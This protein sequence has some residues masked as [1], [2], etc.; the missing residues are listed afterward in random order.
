AYHGAPL[1]EI[2][3][4]RGVEPAGP[5]REGAGVA[6]GAIVEVREH[7]AGS[8]AAAATHPFGDAYAAR[9]PAGHEGAAHEEEGGRGVA[10]AR[11]FGVLGEWGL[12]L[13]ALL[14]AAAGIGLALQMYLYRPE[15]PAAFAARA[16]A[17]Y[18]MVAGK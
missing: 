12:A 5:G 17:L 6:T 11:H 8:P 15:M 18:R 10:S 7:A 9:E 16:G 4:A 1:E 2:Q 13:F 14:V 3:R